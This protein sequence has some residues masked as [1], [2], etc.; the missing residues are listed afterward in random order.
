MAFNAENKNVPAIKKT[1][2]WIFTFCA[3]AQAGAATSELPVN[4][5]RYRTIELRTAPTVDSLPWNGWSTGSVRWIDNERV[6]FGAYDKELRKQ[7][8]RDGKLVNIGMETLHLWNTSTGEVTRYWRGESLPF[9]VAGTFV[10]Y[11]V[12]QNGRMVVREG[13]FGEEKEREFITSRRAPD[14]KDLNSYFNRFECQLL[15]I[16]T[17]L[18]PNKGIVTPLRNEHG[19]FE[20]DH[21][22]A[23]FK[24]GEKARRW[25]HKPNGVSIELPI[26]DE[27]IAGPWYSKFLNVYLVKRRDSS[28]SRGMA[29]KLYLLY[30]DSGQVSELTIPGSPSWASLSNQLPVKLGLIATSS[31]LN[32]RAS[33]DPAHAGLYLFSGPPVEKFFSNLNLAPN[34]DTPAPSDIRVERISR[35]LISDLDVSGDGCKVVML[36]D[37]WDKEKRKAYLQIVDLCAKGK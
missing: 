24:P 10:R 4:P 7:V 19:Q 22:M 23:V 30:P 21:D 27:W 29:N 6:L 8:Q 31:E 32:V 20:D 14:G 18:G 28:I 34:S 25:L 12:R 1:T 11:T 2:C 13:R 36:I 16:N 15:W 3:I 26:H 37:P 17:R 33:W 5:S 35:G 9:C